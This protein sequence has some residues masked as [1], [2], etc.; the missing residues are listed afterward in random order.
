VVAPGNG[1]RQELFHARTSDGEKL[2]LVL[3]HDGRLALLCA[4]RLVRSVSSSQQHVQELIDEFLLLADI[5][6]DRE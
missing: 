1:V 6:T 3:L 5:E 2:S 4:G